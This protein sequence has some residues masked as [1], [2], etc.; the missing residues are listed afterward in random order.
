MQSRASTRNKTERHWHRGEMAGI[1]RQTGNN[2]SGA[3]D[4]TQDCTGQA[5]VGNVDIERTCVGIVRINHIFLSATEYLI[6]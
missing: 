5:K 6:S 1:T 4:G 3:L 2:D